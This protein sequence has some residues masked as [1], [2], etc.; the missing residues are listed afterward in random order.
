MLGS[1]PG[2]IIEG[3]MAYTVSLEQYLGLTLQRTLKRRTYGIWGGFWAGA[4]AQRGI[5]SPLCVEDEIV[6][7]EDTYEHTVAQYWYE[8]LGLAVS[9]V[10]QD[11]LASTLGMRLMERDILEQ[12]RFLD[13]LAEKLRP[14]WQHLGT[15]DQLAQMFAPGGGH[16]FQKQLSSAEPTS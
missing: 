2:Q 6:I 11:S 15:I 16:A 13:E 9:E 12:R 3:G 10:V 14:W 5:A 7:P 1:A 4:L 8:A